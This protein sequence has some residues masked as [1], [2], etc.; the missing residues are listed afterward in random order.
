LAAAG[1]ALYASRS[2]PQVDITCRWLREAIPLPL[3]VLA[4]AGALAWL[5]D[6]ALRLPVVL[7]VA[8][9]AAFLYDAHATM[10]Q[11]WGIRRFVPIVIPGVMVLAAGALVR[12]TRATLGAR[13]DAAAI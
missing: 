6:P 9:G 7:V 4:A 1:A 11:L 3:L 10:N 13:G 8:V 12:A 5:R 2:T